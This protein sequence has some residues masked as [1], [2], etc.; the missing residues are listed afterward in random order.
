MPWETG[1]NTVDYRTLGVLLPAVEQQDTHRKDKVKMLIEKFENYP[2][3]E[4]FLQDFKQ[5]K[6]INEFSK[7]SQDLTADM[8]NTEIFELCETSSK[9]QCLDC[10]SYWEIGIVYCSCGRNLKSSHT[11]N[12]PSQQAPS[13]P[14]LLPCPSLSDLVGAW[15]RV[16][17]NAA[18]VGNDSCA[19]VLC[20]DST[21]RTCMR[22]SHADV[23]RD[24]YL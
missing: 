1:S 5:T 10:N 18:T 2:N 12:N 24:V 20:T 23:Y 9:Q 17:C 4:S 13:S 6:E 22:G 8:N 3:K 14:P 21:V 15:A 11:L 7:K 19:T 16:P